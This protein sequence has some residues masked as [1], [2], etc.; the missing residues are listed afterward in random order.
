MAVG[1]R[2]PASEC[3]AIVCAIC[4]FANIQSMT[5]RDAWVNS[6]VASEYILGLQGGPA[7]GTHTRLRA[8]AACKHILIYDGQ[9]GTDVN[10][11][12]R[13]LNDYYMQPWHG[14][15]AVGH[16]SSMMCSYGAVNGTPD[17]A[18]GALINGVIRKE[19]NW[20]G[21]VVSDCDAVQG[22]EGH[23]PGIAHDA[24]A[25]LAITGG[26]DLNCGPQY[27]NFLAPA[28]S[29]GLVSRK[30]VEEAA[31]R[32]LEHQIALGT[33]DQTTPYDDLGLELVGSDAHAA[34]AYDAAAQGIILLK[35]DRKHLPLSLE[36]GLTVAVIGPHGKRVILSRSAWCPSR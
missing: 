18:D 13:D 8:T 28:V 1:K 5:F 25:A 34:S 12:T 24:A 23:I 16:S 30:K 29:S 22:I 4:I 35:N 15:A 7:N 9:S 27:N 33:F 19:W 10:A 3:R 17:C 2:R 6:V 14:C 11:T 32:V 21:F 20:R 31:T 36:Q 26:V